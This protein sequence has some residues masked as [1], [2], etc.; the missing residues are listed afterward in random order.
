[1]STTK[2]LAALSLAAGIA[3]SACGTGSNPSPATGAG[4]SV[5]PGSPASAALP[6]CLSFADIYALVGPE[7][8]G[9]ATWTDGE[10]IATALGSATDLPDL[11][12]SITG[13]GEESGTFDSFVETRHRGPG[14]GARR[15]RGGADH[16]PGLHELERQRDHRRHRQLGRDRSAG[17]ASRSTRSTLDASARSTSRR[18]PAGRC[19]E[20]TAE[21][22]ASNEYPLA[23]DLY[24]Y[25]NEAK[26]AENPAVSA[27]VDFYLADG[28]I[29]HV[30]ETVPYVTSR[31]RRSPRARRPGRRPSP[32]TRP[33]QTA[34]SS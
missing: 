20:P 3:L 15:A 28:T 27:Y 10:D 29:E 22:I 6:E 25:V 2:R 9:F 7:S 8:T 1:M 30:L 13:P 5:A 16:P 24:I 21:T 14:R 34:R 33:R 18:R 11:P 31:T 23:R 4:G 32:A 19:V 12:L 17:S 26:A